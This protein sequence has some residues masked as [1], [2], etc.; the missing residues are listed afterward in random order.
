MKCTCLITELSAY[1]LLI[2]KKI[3]AKILYKFFYAPSRSS[4][5]NGSRTFWTKRYEGKAVFMPS[6]SKIHLHVLSMHIFKKN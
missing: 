4:E 6:W 3:T 2:M 5:I 1:C